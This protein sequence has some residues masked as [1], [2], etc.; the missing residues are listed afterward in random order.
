VKVYLIHGINL[1]P[2]RM[3]ELGEKLAHPFEVIAL[4]GHRGD[5]TRKVTKESF[6]EFAKEQ[7]NTADCAVI[8]FSLGGLIATAL[9]FERSFKKVCLIAPAIYPRGLKLHRPLSIALSSLPVP[10]LSLAPAYYNQNR[11]VHPNLFRALFEL[12]FEVYN[13]QKKINCPGK[14]FFHQKDKL[15]DVHRSSRW[16]EEHT[17]WEIDFVP[18]HKC[19]FNHMLISERSYDGFDE[20]ATRISHFLD[21]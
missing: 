14:V 5:S 2:E 13:S 20:L 17:N 10:I 18:P 1:K 9:S 8:G 6:L 11:I 12:A 19:L 7:I 21:S 15:V 16:I 3:N 4:P